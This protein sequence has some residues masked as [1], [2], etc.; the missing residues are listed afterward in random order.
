MPAAS[1]MATLRFLYIFRMKFSAVIFLW[2]FS[3]T[4]APSNATK[5]KECIVK[6][7]V[8]KSCI[9]ACCAAST[10]EQYYW[11]SRCVVTKGRREQ[12]EVIQHCTLLW[13]PS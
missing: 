7:K 5:C 4:L 1:S 2:L 8:D 9:T 10:I 13:L 12:E 6:C 3:Y 11:Y